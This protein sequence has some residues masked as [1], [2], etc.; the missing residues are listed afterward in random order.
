MVIGTQERNLWISYAGRFCLV[1]LEQVR[2][3]S[4]Y[5]R[6]SSKPSAQDGLDALR[7]AAKATDHVD[8]SQEHAQLDELQFE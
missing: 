4:P 3:L 5:E 1:A 6:F 8:L 7:K 2:R